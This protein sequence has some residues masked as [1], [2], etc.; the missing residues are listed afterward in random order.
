MN[1]LIHNYL[2]EL[3]MAHGPWPRT[4]VAVGLRAHEEIEFEGILHQE[5]FGLRKIY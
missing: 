5:H 3:I 2:R 4:L 1:C